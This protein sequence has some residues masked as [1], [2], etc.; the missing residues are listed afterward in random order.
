MKR[1]YVSPR[2]RASGLGRRLAEDICAQARAAGYHR[3]R[4]DTLASMS[5][6]R[7]V[8]ESLGF[9]AISPYCF[10]PIPDTAFL[11]LDLSQAV[12]ASSNNGELKHKPPKAIQRHDLFEVLKGENGARGDARA[13]S[14]STTS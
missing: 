7:R 14:P 13:P 1:L 10:N 5:A 8:Y 2:A 11:E 6:A 4:L 12:R 3:M 9:Q